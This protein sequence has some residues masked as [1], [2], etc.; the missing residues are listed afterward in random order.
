MKRPQMPL[1]RILREGDAGPYCSKCRSSLYLT[2]KFIPFAKKNC[3]HPRC[4]NYYL[5]QNKINDDID[6]M[7]S[8]IFHFVYRTHRIKCFLIA[9]FIYLL[10]MSLLI[11]DKR[12]FLIISIAGTI[13]YIIDNILLMLYDEAC[14]ERSLSSRC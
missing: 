14:F 9:L 3:I 13:V 1:G 5:A 8:K 4:E 11:Y 2:T 7:N 10:S 12:Q 6:I